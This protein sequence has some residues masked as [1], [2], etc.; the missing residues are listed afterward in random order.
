VHT[1][2]N[3][4]LRALSTGINIPDT[5]CD[6]GTCNESTAAEWIN[7]TTYGFGYRCDNIS[8]SDCSTDFAN[9][10][11]YKHFASSETGETMQPVMTGGNI[12]SDISSQITYKINISAAQEAGI[13]QNSITYIAIP[14]I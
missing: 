12:G 7:L 3:H 14:S 1:Y 6:S 10:S 8:G 2:E 5:T 11:Y 13:Y 4:P 9:P